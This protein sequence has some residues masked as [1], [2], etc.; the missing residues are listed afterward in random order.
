MSGRMLQR[1]LKEQQARPS[2]ILEESTG[3]DLEEDENYVQKP[4]RNMFDLLGSE[5]RFLLDSLLT[6][7]PVQ[8]LTDRSKIQLLSIATASEM[9]AKLKTPGSSLLHGYYMI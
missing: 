4:V 9:I 3:E 7:F 8:Y 1:A 5:A 2:A 6:I